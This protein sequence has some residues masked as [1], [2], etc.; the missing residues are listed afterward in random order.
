MMALVASSDSDA[1]P[2]WY[3]SVCVGGASD[4]T[5]ARISTV[6]PAHSMP[7][8]T[9]NASP[10]SVFGSTPVEKPLENASAMPE[11]ASSTPLHWLNDSRSPGTSR[12]RPSAVKIGAV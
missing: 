5:D 10:S 6:V 8:P 1:T 3:S 4:S 2:S 12:C 9:P 11:K 7:A